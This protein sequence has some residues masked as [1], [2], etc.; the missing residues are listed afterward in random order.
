M[1]PPRRLHCATAQYRLL[2]HLSPVSHPLGARSDESIIDNQQ[3]SASVSRI[4]RASSCSTKAWLGKLQR[5]IPDYAT[6]AGP[7]RGRHHHQVG[8]VEWYTSR[9]Y[10]CMYILCDSITSCMVRQHSRACLHA[11]LTSVECSALILACR[12][13]DCRGSR[14]TP[15]GLTDELVKVWSYECAWATKC[16]SLVCCLARIANCELQVSQLRPQ[17]RSTHLGNPIRGKNQLLVNCFLLIM[18]HSSKDDNGYHHKPRSRVA[19][20]DI[21]AKCIPARHASLHRAALHCT[22]RSRVAQE[23]KNPSRKAHQPI[24]TD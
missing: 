1:P 15:Q 24:H 8:T 11:W 10:V 7:G 6:R 16:K 5:T 21:P 13:F 9:M 3:L 19:S 2:V 14:A 12:L 18:A 20:A 22:A 17:T 23:N 4:R